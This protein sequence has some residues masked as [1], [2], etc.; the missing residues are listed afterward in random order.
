[1]LRHHILLAGNDYCFFK[2]Y[3]PHGNSLSVC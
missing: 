3:L 1:M 2:D